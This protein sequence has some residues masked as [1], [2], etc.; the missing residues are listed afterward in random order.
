MRRN[1]METNRL[2]QLRLKH[3]LKQKDLANLLGVSEMTISRWEKEEKLSIKHEYIVKLSKYF[4]VSIPYLLGY[5]K[6]ENVSDMENNFLPVNENHKTEISEEELKESIAEIKERVPELA[7][8]DLNYMFHIISY[9]LNQLNALLMEL[10]GA[11]YAKYESGNLTQTEKTVLKEFSLM[12]DNYNPSLYNL[13]T[14][15]SEFMKTV[16][17]KK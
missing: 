3:K 10:L 4:K 12:L 16:A 14:Q 17:F 7:E 13:S 9:E 15:T 8:A 2:K 5:S 6:Y 11:T 1:H